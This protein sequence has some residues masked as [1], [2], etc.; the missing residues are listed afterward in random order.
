M[1]I[2]QDYCKV[3]EDFLVELDFLV[4][5]KTS[6]YRITNRYFLGNNQAL[7]LL[8]LITAQDIVQQLKNIL[9]LSRF[10]I[11][12]PASPIGTPFQQKAWQALQIL[13][14]NSLMSDTRI[15]FKL[16]CSARVVGNTDRKYH[17]QIV[18]PYHCMTA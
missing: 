2:C 15:A 18:F 10:Q 4:G 5:I 11:T 12:I 16:R 3:I 17:V 7:E 9:Y 8:S 13:P 1:P 14:F 6:F